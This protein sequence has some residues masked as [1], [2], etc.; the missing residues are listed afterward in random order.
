VARPSR[1]GFAGFQDPAGKLQRNFLRQP[2]IQRPDLLFRFVQSCSG[3]FD[4]FHLDWLTRIAAREFAVKIFRCQYCQL[5]LL[6]DD[7]ETQNRASAAASV[8]IVDGPGSQ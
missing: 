5:G 1:P 2:L 4:V 8:R 7:S 6:K 3:S